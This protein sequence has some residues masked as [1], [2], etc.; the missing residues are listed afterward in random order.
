MMELNG[1]FMCAD[2][3]MVTSEEG[4]FFLK[5]TADDASTLCGVNGPFMCADCIMVTL[6]LSVECTLSQSQTNVSRCTLIIW[7]S[8]VRAVGSSQ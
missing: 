6:R 2:C 7:T 3:I 5:S 4:Q 8:L 1:P